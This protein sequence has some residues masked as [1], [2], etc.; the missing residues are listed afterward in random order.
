[1][2]RPRKPLWPPGHRGFESLTLRHATNSVSSDP[3]VPAPAV[4]VRGR[5]LAAGHDPGQHLCLAFSFERDEPVGDGV[6]RIAAAEID[7]ALAELGGE[8][9]DDLRKVVHSVRKRGKRFRA[10]LRLVRPELGEGVPP[11]QRGGPGRRPRPRP[12]PR[13]PRPP[14]DLRCAGRRERP[15]SGRP[16][17]AGRAGG[18]GAASPGGDGPDRHRRPGGRRGEGPP[19]LDPGRRR[20]LGD[21]RRL[22]CAGPRPGGHLPEGPGRLPIRSS[23]S[24][25]PRRST[26]G[27]REPSTSGTRPSSSPRPP[28][29]PSDPRRTPCTRWPTPSATT[30]TWSSSSTSC[31]P[32]PT[33]SAVARRSRRPSTWRTGAGPIWRAGR[34]RWAPA[35]TPRSPRP[36]WT[37][38]RATGTP[39][40]RTATSCP[41]GEI[42]TI[43]PPDDG[44]DD[45]TRSELYDLARAADIVGRSAMDRDDLIASLRAGRQ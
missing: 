25:P 3:P 33:A 31:G 36:S 23:S 24:P 21:R 27:A 37:G 5:R 30:T 26:S 20:R 45:L 41:T 13:G 22:Q 7:K 1:M 34:W 19:R 29:A 2:G 14:R 8:R 15:G 4:G 9:H 12:H 43:A 40:R 11:G 35:S 28:P 39:G 42:G 6:R 10:L 38:R 16:R 18:P 32:T 17:P 44:L